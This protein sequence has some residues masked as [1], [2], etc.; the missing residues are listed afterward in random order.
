MFSKIPRGFNLPTE[1]RKNDHKLESKDTA[2]VSTAVN[3][4]HKSDGNLKGQKENMPRKNVAPK[5]IK[6]VSSR[7]GHQVELKEQNQHLMA[8]NE[9]LQKNLSETQQKVSELELHVSELKKE[10]AEVQKHLQD[11]HVLLVSAKVDPVLGE[12][13]GDAA[14]QKE[15]QR[16]EVM[17]ISTDLLKELKAFGDAA[18]VQRAQLE[19]IQATMV[20]FTEARGHMKQ[21]RENFSQQAAE[22]EKALTEAETLLL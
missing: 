22:L 8:V 9:D 12:R 10:N 20:N 3:A 15:D 1:A 17:S 7:Y 14:K 18:S 5:V 2:T 16:K 11:C 13:V 6:G 19:E 21:E 4:V